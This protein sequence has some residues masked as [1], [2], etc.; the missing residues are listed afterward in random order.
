MKI[1]KYEHRYEITFVV[2]LVMIIYIVY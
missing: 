2:L 1:K